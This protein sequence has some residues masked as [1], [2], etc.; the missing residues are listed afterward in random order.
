[1]RR[2]CLLLLA[3]ACH[4][5][6]AAP[7]PT[8]TRCGTS[9]PRAP[10]S[11]SLPPRARWAREPRARDRAQVVATPDFVGTSRSSTR[12]SPATSVSPTRRSP[13]RPRPAASRCSSPRTACSARCRSPTATSSSPQARHARLRRR[14]RHDQRRDRASR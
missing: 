13:S 5:V 7:G 11:A 4:K 2:A 1:M 9:P 12:S 10:S 8:P 14:R 6:A 3:A